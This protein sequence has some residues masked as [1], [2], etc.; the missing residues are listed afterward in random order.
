[1][2]DNLLEAIKEE[3]DT[4]LKLKMR[5]NREAYIHLVPVID[6]D[7]KSSVAENTVCMSLVKIEED[8]NN[9]AVPP[10]HNRVNGQVH[11]FNPPVKLHL[12]V[13]FSA[14]T[15]DGQE[16]NYTEA[17]KRITH[18]IAF[19]Q[20][21]NVFTSANTPRLEQGFG[22]VTAELFNMTMEEQNNLWGMLGGVYR[23]SVLYK[24]R[25]VLVQEEHVRAATGPVTETDVQFT[26]NR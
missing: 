3:V 14:S 4:Y 7:G 18:V 17:L 23:P 13:L 8:K 19:F 20:S 10:P 24:L 26:E 16:K 25:A 11:Y 5:D 2:I 1:M 9:M 15:S 12:F 22:K 6:Q 21:K